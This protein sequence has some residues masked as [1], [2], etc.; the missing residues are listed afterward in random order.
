MEEIK[1]TNTTENENVTTENVIQSKKQGNDWI[2]I[3]RES[4]QISNKNNLNTTTEE[5]SLT[6]LWLNEDDGSWT[7]QS[8]DAEAGPETKI[9]DWVPITDKIRNEKSLKL[10]TIENTEKSSTGMIIFFFFKLITKKIIFLSSI[11]QKEVK[12]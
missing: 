12:N 1:S 2:P 5:K 10:S 3:N 11:L 6:G 9:D 8:E 4:K 7:P